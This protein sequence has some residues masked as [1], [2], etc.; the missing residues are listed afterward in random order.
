M[1]LKTALEA[2]ASV[3]SYVQRAV[4]PEDLREMVRLAGLAPSLNNAQ[5]WRY[6]AIV[7]A[8]KCKHVAKLV[9]DKLDTILLTPE[10]DAQRRATS[11]LRDYVQLFGEAPALLIVATRTYPGFLDD[12]LMTSGLAVD[13]ADSVRGHP[14]AMSLGASIENLLLAA[15]DMGYGACWLTAPQVAA[16]QIEQYVRIEAPWRLGAVISVGEPAE[17]SRQA[18]KKSI[19]DIFEVFEGG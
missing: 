5:P 19:G 7:E 16:A 12:A 9:W 11:K 4:P 3:R 1:E 14:Y 6:I 10:T 17:P 8:E 18:A 2:R 15:T 13:A